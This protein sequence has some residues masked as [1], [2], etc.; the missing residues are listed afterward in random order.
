MISRV[1]EGERTAAAPCRICSGKGKTSIKRE[2]R[3]VSER[4]EGRLTRKARGGL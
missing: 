2:W 3:P 1:I 4:A